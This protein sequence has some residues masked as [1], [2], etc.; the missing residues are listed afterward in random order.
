MTRRMV[1]RTSSSVPKNDVSN[2]LN[3][4]VSPQ[5]EVPVVARGN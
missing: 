2:L 1:S 5:A 3:N 4:D